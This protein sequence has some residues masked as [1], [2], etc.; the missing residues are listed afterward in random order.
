LWVSVYKYICTYTYICSYICK[1][2]YWHIYVVYI[3]IYIHIYIYIYMYICIYIYIHTLTHTHTHKVLQVHV[4]SK[5]NVLASIWH[6]YHL[7][8]GYCL[9]VRSIYMCACVCVYV[10]VYVCIYICV[11]VS[12][13]ESN[14]CICVRACV[15][16]YVCVCA[17]VC[18]YVGISETVWWFLM[19]WS[20][21]IF[22]WTLVS[23]VD[24]VLPCDLKLWGLDA[25]DLQTRGRRISSHV[26]AILSCII[27]GTTHI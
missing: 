26:V 15:C 4:S 5:D 21:L 10:C 24:S 14:L 19:I 3:Y 23:F 17:Y 25:C 8:C 2:S 27:L 20:F 13:S 22:S 18:V 6:I 12:I 7:S 1:K 11:C 16:M 9:G